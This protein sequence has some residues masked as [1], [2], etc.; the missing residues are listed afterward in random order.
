MY[1]LLYWLVF[2]GFLLSPS[3]AAEKAKSKEEITKMINGLPNL[4]EKARSK[5]AKLLEG[6]TRDMVDGAGNMREALT[7]PMLE[8][9]LFLN[10]ES[11]TRAER[12]K[13]LQS[14]LQGIATYKYFAASREGSPG[15][16]VQIEAAGAQL[17]HVENIIE[18]FVTN[19]HENHGGFDLDAW[20]TRW[21]KAAQRDQNEV[22]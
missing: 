16:L 11:G 9:D 5:N 22:Q 1:K 18:T 4:V 15:T 12:Q 2:L 10:P 17:E 6:S 21:L 13:Q 7:G 14:D 8:L 20:R 3:F 19:F